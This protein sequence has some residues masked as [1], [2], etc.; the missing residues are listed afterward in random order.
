MTRIEWTDE[1]WNPV[2]GCTKVSEGCDN[3]YAERMARRLAGR[4]GYDADS[5]F[6]VTLH[7]NRLTEPAKWRKPRRVFVCSM[8]DLFH[9]GVWPGVQERIFQIMTMCHEHTFQ[10][11]TKRPEMMLGF[12][13]RWGDGKD[14]PENIW[15]GVTAENQKR[16]HERI[17]L[18]LE[19]PAKV[20][21]VSCEPLLGPVNLMDVA[22]L[23]L[24]GISWVIAGCESGPRRRPAKKRWFQ[25]LRDQC[26]G[27][28]PFF[29][30]QME[31]EAFDHT[32]TGPEDDLPAH[33]SV[34]KLPRLDGEQ[35]VEWPE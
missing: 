4:C 18:L 7:E 26:D 31:V 21:F 30:K 27:R 13:R 9:A 10:V 22:G 8:G 25:D 24:A 23:G 1:T 16:A 32:A 20:K 5:P 12:A 11:L 29:L 35:Y 17:P 14:W 6:R 28:V 15:L 34:V 3:C 33:T 2:T 19:T